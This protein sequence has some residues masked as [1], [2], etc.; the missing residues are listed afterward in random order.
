[1]RLRGRDVQTSEPIE[2]TISGQTIESVAP[3]PGADLRRSPRTG[4]EASRAPQ[5]SWDEAARGPDVLGG[6]GLWLAPALFD[7]QV[8]GFGGR[9]L[10]AP[11]TTPE[12]VAAVMRLLWEGGVARFCPTVTTQ[13]SERMTASL[14]AIREA[15]ETDPQVAHATVTLHI[16]GPYISSE[17][18]PRGA[19]PRAHTRPPDLDEFRRM[20]DAAGGRIGYVTLAPELPGAIPFVE[21]LAAEGIVVSLGHHGGSA[22]TIRD[23]VAAGARHCTHL[24]NG[25]HATLPRHPNYIWEQMAEDRLTAGIIADGH[26][27]PPSVLKSMVRSKGLERAVLVSDAIA[28]AGL[29]PGRYPR[30]GGQTLEITPEGRIQV[31]DTPYLAGS[32]LRLNEGVANTVRFAGTTLAETFLLATRN[33]ARVFGVGGAYGDL[34]PGMAADLLLF[35]WD[36]DAARLDVVATIAAGQVVY[37]ASRSTDPRSPAG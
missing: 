11:D 15:C 30:P 12:D 10:N 2:V 24:G 31:A 14:R 35:R 7:S 4:G 16:E 26:H 29:P 17:D 28:A 5:T 8:N 1:V 18:G 20:Q 33:P 25:A 3:A 22:E 37:Q 9:D 19:H 34:A 6:D 27:L 23:A 13:S 32:G 21:R 36:E